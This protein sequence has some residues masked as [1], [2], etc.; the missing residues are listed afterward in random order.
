MSGEAYASVGALPVES[1]SQQLISL[2]FNENPHGPSA[3]VADTIQHELTRLDRYANIT[4]GKRIAEQIATYE[5][6][7]DEPVVLGEILWLLGLYLGRRGGEFIHLLNTGLPCT[8]RRSWAGG[9]RWRDRPVECAVPKRS[10]RQRKDERAD[11][12]SLSS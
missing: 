12:R 9:R 2:L 3:N 5:H 7:P 10:L 6:L 8:Y 1:S 4:A 11:S